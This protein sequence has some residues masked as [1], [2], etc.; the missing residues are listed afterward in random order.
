MQYVPPHIFSL[1]EATAHLETR[2]PRCSD[3]S[4]IHN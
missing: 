1:C 4:I 3:F 2:S